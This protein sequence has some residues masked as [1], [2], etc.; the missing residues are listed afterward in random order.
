MYEYKCIN[1]QITVAPCFHLFLTVFKTLALAVKNYVGND[2]MYCDWFYLAWRDG[3][4]GVPE[5]L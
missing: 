1:M 3:C 2:M 5:N 4:T